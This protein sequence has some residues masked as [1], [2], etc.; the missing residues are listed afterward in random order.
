MGIARGLLNAIRPHTNPFGVIS[1]HQI[2]TSSFLSTGLAIR[3]YE[4]IMAFSVNWWHHL[5][6][7]CHSWANSLHQSVNSWQKSPTIFCLSEVSGKRQCSPCCVKIEPDGNLE[8]SGNPKA[9]KDQKT[10][11]NKPPNLFRNNN[12]E[13]P[14][15]PGRPYPPPP[16]LL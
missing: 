4:T 6:N 2:S 7:W 12:W 14:L 15:P 13:S 16:P 11:N 10:P 9:M 8:A 5:T 3:K 1:L